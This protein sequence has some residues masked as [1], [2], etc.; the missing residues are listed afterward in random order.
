MKQLMTTPNYSNNSPR[1]V[2]SRLV[3]KEQKKLS[4][5]TFGIVFLSVI[6]LIFFIFVLLPGGV[7]LFFSILDS[8]TGLDTTDTFPPQVPILSSPVEATYSA[9]I[10]LSGFA[11][12]ESTVIL[13]LDGQKHDE[14]SVTEA[15]E[16]EYDFKLKEGEN[17]FVLY[18]IDQV[19]NTSETT[20]KYVVVYDKDAPVITIESP[21]NDA[22]IESK[23]NQVLSISGK[24]EAGAKIYLND[25]LLSTR[26]DGTFTGTYNLSEGE[27]S[28]KFRAIDRAGNE[29][30]TE[31]KVTFRY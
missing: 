6:I 17:S 11:E 10:K 31:L 5:Q 20:R 22:V 26:S 14:I 9:S 19:E 29:S 21:E 16:F 25:R 24:T 2:T 3:R 15:G 4:R 13:V 1:R 27:N 8:N 18:G 28:L 12:P 30:E 7:R 23:I